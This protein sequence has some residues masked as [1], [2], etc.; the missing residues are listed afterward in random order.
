[1]IVISKGKW[2]W[3]LCYMFVNK[4]KLKLK[5]FSKRLGLDTLLF[6]NKK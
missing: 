6:K 3:F 2:N 5:R 4:L 1:M